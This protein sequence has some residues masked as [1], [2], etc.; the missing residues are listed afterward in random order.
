MSVNWRDLYNEVD[1]ATSGYAA[2]QNKFDALCNE[3]INDINLHDE[4]TGKIDE[5]LAEEARKKT[6]KIMDIKKLVIYE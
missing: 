1:A 3:F 6:Y 5:E 2:L 4:L